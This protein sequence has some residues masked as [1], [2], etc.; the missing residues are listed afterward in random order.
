[1]GKQ[2]TIRIPRSWKYIPFRKGGVFKLKKAGKMSKKLWKPFEDKEGNLIRSS[3][4]RYVPGEAF[5][6]DYKEWGD[7]LSELISPQQ[8][9]GK[10]PEVIIHPNESGE[11]VSFI[12]R[13]LGKLESVFGAD[14]SRVFINFFNRAEVIDEVLSIIEK[15]GSFQTLLPIYENLA[16]TST[17]EVFYGHYARVL[18]SRSQDLYIQMAR[19]GNLDFETDET[20]QIA[21]IVL[22][23]TIDSSSALYHFVRDVYGI[24]LGSESDRDCRNLSYNSTEMFRE[25]IIRE[26]S[27]P[28]LEMILREFGDR[29]EERLRT[30][31]GV[32][33][34]VF[35]TPAFA[36]LLGTISEARH[37]V[38]LPEVKRLRDMGIQG[39]LELLIRRT[40][41]DLEMAQV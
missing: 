6:K 27:G 36:A 24:K 2:K 41:R 15:V 34:N 37:V 21:A 32:N 3:A 31:P 5:P 11:A 33:H 17:N 19:R 39:Q 18:V 10:R 4:L 20:L 40:I 7:Q 30:E 22:H 29:I 28:V 14:Y 1:M 8:R 9:S 35:Y 38:C 12:L 23:M 25:L 26:E 13:E 16:G